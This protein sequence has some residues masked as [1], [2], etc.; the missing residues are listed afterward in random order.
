MD[1]LSNI[2]AVLIILS[3]ASERL[4]EI[5]KSFIPFLNNAKQDAGEENR[6]KAYLNIL[7]IG[8][9]I[10]TAYISRGAL[11]SFFPKNLSNDI[12]VITFGLLASG[13]SGF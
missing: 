7:A 3:I 2:I 1:T 11:S 10:L 8:A 12:G 6:R 4:V 13:G 9:G 5:V